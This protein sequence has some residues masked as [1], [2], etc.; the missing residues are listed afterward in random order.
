MKPRERYDW[1]ENYIRAKAHRPELGAV[2]VC[3]SDFVDDYV[4]AT[5]AEVHYV[6]YGANKCPQLGRDLATMVGTLERSRVGLQGM[7]GMGFP[8][9]VWSYRL[10]NP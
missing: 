10:R 4:A 8:R 7:A 2:D 6:M 9:W 3:D 5:G 1:I